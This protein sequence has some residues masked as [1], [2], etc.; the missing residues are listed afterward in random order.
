M[1]KLVTRPSS[2]CGSEPAK[3]SQ[4]MTYTVKHAFVNQAVKR[5]WDRNEEYRVYQ[6]ASVDIV[7]LVVTTC[8]PSIG[9]SD[10]NRSFIVCPKTIDSRMTLDQYSVDVRVYLSANY[11][12]TEIWI[13]YLSS[14]GWLLTDCH[15]TVTRPLADY[16]S[17]IDRFIDRL[18]TDESTDYRQIYRPIYQRKIPN[19]LPHLLK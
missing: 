4:N 18:L 7:D 16:R 6:A 15:P 1:P 11:R 13:D 3:M 14:V 10:D 5:W 2:W 19:G 9:T 12:H 17:T 8:T